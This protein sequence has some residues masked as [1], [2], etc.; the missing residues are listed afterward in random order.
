M[1][2]KRKKGESK[3]FQ[4]PSDPHK[5]TVKVVETEPGTRFSTTL[6]VVS[7]QKPYGTAFLIRPETLMEIIEWAGTK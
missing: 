1:Q 6:Q 4:G 5:I 7:R 2:I 3:D